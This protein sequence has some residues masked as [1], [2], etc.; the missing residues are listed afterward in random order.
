ML[1]YVSKPFFPQEKIVL[2]EDADRILLGKKQNCAHGCDGAILLPTV[3][4]E[5]PWMA[6]LIA[7]VTAHAVH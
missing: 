5:M 1:G 4:Q 6:F 2:Q 3:P 7:A